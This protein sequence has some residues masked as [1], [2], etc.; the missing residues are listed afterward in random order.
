MR[1]SRL[2]VTLLLGACLIA[3]GQ[4]RVPVAMSQ[5]LVTATASDAPVAAVL[6]P[7][8]PVLEYTPTV[9]ATLVPSPTAS[10]QPPIAAAVLPPT[11]VMPTEPPT[12]E[13]TPTAVAVEPRPDPSPSASPT[14]EPPSPVAE[15]TP[16]PEPTAVPDPSPTPTPLPPRP[17]PSIGGDLGPTVAALISGY[18]DVGLAVA[19]VL[20]TVDCGE[21]L[22]A[23]N[24][25]VVLPTASLYKLF[26]LWQVQREIGA[27]RLSDDT[28]LLLTPEND[29]SEDDGYQLGEYGEGI[30]VAEARELMIARSN[31]TAAWVLAQTVGWGAIDELLMANGFD[32]SRAAEGVTTPRE[33]ARF[34]DS[35]L[36]QTLDP[37]L[38]AADYALMLDLLA[39]QEVNYLLSTGLPSDVPFA[40]KTGSL[41]GITNDAGIVT[42]PDGRTLTIVALLTG[43]EGAS[44]ALMYDLAVLVWAYV[45][46]P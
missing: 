14:P 8:M 6:A 9:P 23:F 1:R 43:D 5:P 37:K 3:C 24:A 25:D 12:P 4:A 7:V 19:G 22:V 26:V 17:S 20:V 11:P 36:T 2:L 35:L 18:E 27:G 15:E 33:I 41:P 32:S 31:N 39:R 42:L 38:G 46:G 21:P 40:H 13:P 28:V 10:A 44:Q 30:T 16:V 34:F 29:D 45:A